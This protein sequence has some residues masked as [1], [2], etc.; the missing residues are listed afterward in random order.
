MWSPA[1]LLSM[2]RWID[3]WLERAAC[4]FILLTGLAIAGAAPAAVTV[5][6]DQEPDVDQ[7]LPGGV[8]GYPTGF[9]VEFFAPV[10]QTFVPTSSRHVGVEL[11]LSRV[12][13]ALAHLPAIYTAELRENFNG[14]ALASGTTPAI[15]CPELSGTGEWV[16]ILFDEP[17][18]LEPGQTYFLTLATAN[19]AGF[20]RAAGQ[21][22]YPRG[23]AIISGSPD[24][25]FDWGFR[26]L[27]IATE[28][29]EIDIMP[30]SVSNPVNPKSRRSIRVAILGTDDFD[31]EEIDVETLA[32]GPQG[33]APARKKGG[34]LKDVNG[35]GHTDLVLHYP[36]EETG[37]AAGDEEACVTGD[38]FDGTPFKG[39]DAI[40]TLG[41]RGERF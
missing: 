23:H 36:V 16:E 31:V 15:V 33:A 4:A 29:I 34:G 18:S 3:R 41:V 26:T 30:R 39:C 11:V 27:V 22:R 2:D 21:N 14:P 8:P 9:R 38:V 5:I 37:I 6:I 32:F 17:A 19:Q 20:W 13:L 28:E 25:N 10:G 24:A 1:A 12:C 7:T 35:D 40:V